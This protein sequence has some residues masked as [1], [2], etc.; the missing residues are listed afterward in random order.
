MKVNIEMFLGS[1]VHVTTEHTDSMG[2]VG[3]VP[4]GH[5]NKFSRSVQDPLHDLG[6]LTLEQ[7]TMLQKPRY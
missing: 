4:D 2:E 3:S 5:V 7:S 1:I 6:L